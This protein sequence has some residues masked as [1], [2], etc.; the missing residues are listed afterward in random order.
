MPIAPV[1]RSLR[2]LALLFLVV[3]LAACQ[4]GTKPDLSV[5]AADIPTSF[6]LVLIA[7]KDDQFDV[8]GAPLTA[9]DLKAHMRY[10]QA[11]SLPMS[12]VLVKRGEKQKVKDSHIV[13]L[14]RMARE[15]NFRAFIEERDGS[16][17]E[18]IS[19]VKSK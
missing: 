1:A 10:R 4:R 2:L 12:T 5:P 15:M 14:A 13:P 19:S 7:E 16:I 17:S 9:E 3:V 6:D 8:L 11:E 18:I